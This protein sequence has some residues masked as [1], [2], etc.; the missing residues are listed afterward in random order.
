MNSHQRRV[1]TIE[2]TLTP[3]QVVFVWLRNAV[4]AGTFVEGARH[5]PPYRG[6]VVD[7]VDETV[8][9]SMKGHP[10]LLIERAILQARREADLLYMLILNANISVLESAEQSQREYFLLC[11]YFYAALTGKP[12]RESIEHLRKALLLFIEPI[13]LLDAVIAQL[14]AGPLKHHPMLFRDSKEKL[15]ERL[16]MAT[17]LS[18]GFRLIETNT[19]NNAFRVGGIEPRPHWTTRTFARFMI[20]AR[21]VGRYRMNGFERYRL[22]CIRP[23]PLTLVVA[24]GTDAH[25]LKCLNFSAQ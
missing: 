17:Q 5:S 24:P 9:S 20:L 1:R 23:S 25:A 16:E 14:V 15:A 2:L 8:R 4:Q 12:T 10:E 11:G 18:T 13:V 21:G 3:E 19:V 7:A 22:D 6:M